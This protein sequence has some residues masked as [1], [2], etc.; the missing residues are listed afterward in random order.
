VAEDQELSRRLTDTARST[1]G[2]RHVF[3][4][5]SI[6]QVAADAVAVQLEL[7]EPDTLVDVDRDGGAVRITAEI[8]VDGGR[9]ATPGRDRTPSP[10]SSGW[11]RTPP[12]TDAARRAADGPPPV[13]ESFPILPSALPRPSAAP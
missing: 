7:R 9:P 1:D 4:A 11:W 2:V 3:P 6:V 5:A 8:A 13:R 12:G 10:S